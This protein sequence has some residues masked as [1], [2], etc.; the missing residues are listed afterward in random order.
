MV[1]YQ[2]KPYFLRNLHSLLH[3]FS[4][5]VGDSRINRLTG[6]HNL[7]QGQHSLHQR[8]IRIHTMV[9]ENIH[10]IQLHP[11]QGGVT[12]C[13]QILSGTAISIGT[14]PH[15]IA[16]L[17]A[18]QKLFPIRAKISLVQNTEISLRLSIGGTVIVGQIKMGNAQVEGLPKNILHLLLR[19]PFSEVMPKPQRN[20][21]KI[22][23]GFPRLSIFHAIITI[24]IGYI[25]FSN[26]H[27]IPPEAIY[28]PDFSKKEIYWGSP[29]TKSQ[30]YSPKIKG[31]R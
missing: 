21:R 12:A 31:R 5:I 11:F 13:E 26:I 29:S 3:A 17:S 2:G 7:K 20:R 4:V 9:I 24:F 1:N 16:C 28:F 10:V 30:L 27:L 14:L 25:S 8:G 22:Q 6:L 23:T 15:I 19:I 18:N